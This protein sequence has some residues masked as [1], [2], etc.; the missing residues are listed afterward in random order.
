MSIENLPTVEPDALLPSTTQGRRWMFT[1]FCGESPESSDARLDALCGLL[2][3]PT[4]RGYVYQLES[5]PDT[6]SL[7]WQGYIVFKRP[8]R[9]SALRGLLATA[10]WEL[11]RGDHASCFAYCSKEETRVDGPWPSSATFATE[12]QGMDPLEH[13]G[14][15]N[16]LLIPLLSADGACV[17]YYPA[18]MLVMAMYHAGITAA[19]WYD[20]VD[21]DVGDT[22]VSAHAI[23]APGGGVWWHWENAE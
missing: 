21:F 13:G 22:V 5:A 3:S 17:T 23:T 11:A 10:H 12:H 20:S 7:H 9:L 2:G 1:L 15:W 18:S 4:V 14:A 16:T 8:I 19:E 6:G